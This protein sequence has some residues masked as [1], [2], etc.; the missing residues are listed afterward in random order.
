MV[1][2]N[3]GKAADIAPEKIFEPALVRTDLIG[4]EPRFEVREADVVLGVASDF[5]A[6]S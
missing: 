6:A 3:I 1:P 5:K 4:G 2:A